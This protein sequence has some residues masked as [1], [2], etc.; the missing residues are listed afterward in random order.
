LAHRILRDR[1]KQIKKEATHSTTRRIHRTADNGYIL[2]KDM[3][4]LVPNSIDA[5]AIGYI[6][7]RLKR[8]LTYNEKEALVG[9]IEPGSGQEFKDAV[10]FWFDHGLSFEGRDNMEDFRTNYLTRCA[11]RREREWAKEKAQLHNTKIIDLF[12][13]SI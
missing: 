3:K 12:D 9:N 7:R 6:Q 10:D 2:K 1:T 5:K 8:S 13:V 4:A 11:D